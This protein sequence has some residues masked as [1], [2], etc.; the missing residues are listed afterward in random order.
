[1]PYRWASTAHGDRPGPL[2]QFPD[3]IPRG[4]S[5]SETARHARDLRPCAARSR[6]VSQLARARE[7]GTT[8]SVGSRRRSSSPADGTNSS[9]GLAHEHSRQPISAT[10]RVSPCRVRPAPAPPPPPP[11][12]PPLHPPP[13]PFAMRPPKGK[14]RMHLCSSA[15][16]AACGLASLALS[17]RANAAAVLA[18]PNAAALRKALG[19]V[20]AS[21]YAR[22][23]P[24]V[25]CAPAQ[26]GH[27]G[28]AS[29]PQRGAVCQLGGPSRPPCRPSHKASSGA[30]GG[31]TQIC[32]APEAIWRHRSHRRALRGAA[33]CS[34][35]QPRV[36][37]H[38]QGRYR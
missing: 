27:Y 1:M 14:A 4:E 7:G 2:P 29:P 21:N 11:P 33:A 35:W 37:R 13:S 12:P 22:A 15:A 28:S 10:S 18:A 36:P 19:T 30:S 23:F 8:R 24:A 32:D 26:R 16:C 25:W 20:R 17:C 5:S 34:T 38:T 3:G 31:V 6:A 9:S